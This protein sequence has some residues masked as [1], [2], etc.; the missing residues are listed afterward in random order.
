MKM[1]MKHGHIAFGVAVVFL[2]PRVAYFSIVGI[3]KRGQGPLWTAL[4]SER[5]RERE[6]FRTFSI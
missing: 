6:A 4:P 1:L 5:E 3:Q 2:M